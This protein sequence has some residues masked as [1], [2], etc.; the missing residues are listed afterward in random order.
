MK[1]A[2]DF[3]SLADGIAE[4]HPDMSIKVAAF[5]V[6]EKSSNT[7]NESSEG[8][9]WRK[10]NCISCVIIMIMCTEMIT[11][12]FYNWLHNSLSCRSVVKY[13]RLVGGWSLTVPV[14]RLLALL[15]RD[16]LL[17]SILS[18]W[19]CCF[20][21]VVYCCIRRSRLISSW[22]WGFDRNVW[23]WYFLVML[24]YLYTFRLL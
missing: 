22:C 9:S 6:R 4:P 23:F 19:F 2:P 21:L 5:T 14:P 12:Q 20:R 7:E 1:L 11:F 3:P 15:D 8:P 10:N 18:Q 17:P 16:F 13:R 24:I